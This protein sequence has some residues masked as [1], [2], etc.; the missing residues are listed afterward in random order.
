MRDYTKTKRKDFWA[1]VDASSTATEH[2]VN[3]AWADVAE[4]KVLT[5]VEASLVLDQLFVYS[6]D[7]ISQMGGLK[8]V[9]P[10]KQFSHNGLVHD[11]ELWWVD[12]FTAGV[13][14]QATLNWFSA[15][16]LRNGRS[17]DGYA[18]AST[19]FVI[20][21]HGLP[22]Y[23]IP[24]M[25][26]A[27]HEPARNRDSISVE[28]V[29]AGELRQHGGN[30]C[31]WPSKWTRKVPDALVREL[32]P[33]SLDKPYRGCKTM[34]PFTADQ[35]RNN[36]VLKRIVMAALPGKLDMSRMSQH[37]D[38]KTGKKDMGPLWPFDDVNVAAYDRVPLS[39][40]HMLNQHEQSLLPGSENREIPVIEDGDDDGNS[41]EYG[42]DSPTHDDDD[43]GSDKVLTTLEVQTILTKLGHVMTVD[44]KFG[45]QTRQAVKAFQL[46]WNR[47]RGATPA[48]A[49]DGVPG[50]LTC[51]ALLGN[52]SE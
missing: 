28:M 29:N 7:R 39:E 27:W 49:L 30:W 11:K 45:P 13:S 51:K 14:E 52:S 47:R 43:V 25:H 1:E 19:H 8:K 15:R 33:T 40:L 38:W 32:P 46:T 20:P 22:F 34:Q 10:T 31:Y 21:H 37:T 5:Q 9:Y 42:F 26:G 16:K 4:G 24:L 50:P 23:I 12:H 17:K 3:A 36:I 35:I 2:A 41:P 6:H 44:G 18:G 48:L